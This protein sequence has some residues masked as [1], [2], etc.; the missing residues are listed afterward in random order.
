[1]KCDEE[2]TMTYERDRFILFRILT[3]MIILYFVYFI[4]T[5]EHEKS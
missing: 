4:N 1:M 2:F 3:N 5:C